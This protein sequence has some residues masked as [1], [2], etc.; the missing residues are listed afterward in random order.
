MEYKLTVKDGYTEIKFDVPP[1]VDMLMSVNLIRS[2]HER[3]L[4]DLSEGLRMDI[5]GLNTLLATLSTRTL[6]ETAV[7]A[8]VAIDNHEYGLSKIFQ[9]YRE[10]T[11]LKVMVF[12]SKAEAVKWLQYI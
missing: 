3:I 12:R 8:I 9:A 11:G 4:L 6:P 7:T 2:D 10:N 1:D 5:T